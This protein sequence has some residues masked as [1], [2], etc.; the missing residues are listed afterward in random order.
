MSALYVRDT[1]RG[2]LSDRSL[3]WAMPFYDSINIDVNPTDDLWSTLLFITSTAQVVTYCGFV[4]ERGQFDFL[5]L[6]KP[7]AGDSALVAACEHDAAILQQLHDTRGQLTLV[8]AGPLE[9]FLQ[10]GNVPWYSV[11]STFQYL[12]LHPAPVVAMPIT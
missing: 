8:S 11:S 4:E 10:A 3:G 6:G 5:G 1:L 12:Y 9:D 2:W 7:G